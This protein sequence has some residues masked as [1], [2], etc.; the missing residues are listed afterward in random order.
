[1]TRYLTLEDILT[2]HD[3]LVQRF[4][5]TAGVRDLNALNSALGRPQSGYY[6]DVIEEAAALFESIAQNHPFV[7]GNKRTAITATAVFLRL[8][9]CKLRFGDAEAYE[10]MISLFEAKRFTKAAADDWLRAH[11]HRED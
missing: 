11:A 10:W 9:G 1:M 4:G 3:E 5:G 8:N 6:A 2:I 7:D